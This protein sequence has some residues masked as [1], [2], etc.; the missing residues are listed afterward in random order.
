MTAALMRFFND[1]GGGRWANRA[2]WGEGEPCRDRWYG[3]YCCPSSH[4]RLKMAFAIDEAHE[5]TK[6]QCWDDGE[7]SKG[8]SPSTLRMDDDNGCGTEDACVV[9][10]LCVAPPPVRTTPQWG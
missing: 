4:P 8:A 5:P 1:A 6:D 9:V 10:A 7:H 3:V 2:G